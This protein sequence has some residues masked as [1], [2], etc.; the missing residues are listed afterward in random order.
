MRTIP[1]TCFLIIKLRAHTDYVFTV[2]SRRQRL[3]M[4]PSNVVRDAVKKPE[5]CLIPQNTFIVGND[6]SAQGKVQLS[7]S[8][9]NRNIAYTVSYSM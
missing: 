7:D 1:S 2:K 6:M 3:Q 9:K 4:F 5:Y 8:F